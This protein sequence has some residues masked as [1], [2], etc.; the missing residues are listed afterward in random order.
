M[1]EF[2]RVFIDMR[3]KLQ[4]EIDRI[5]QIT[6]YIIPKTIKRDDDDI[7]NK[8]ASEKMY[9][10]YV[11]KKDWMGSFSTE[12]GGDHYMSNNESNVMEFINQKL[13]EKPEL[14]IE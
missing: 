8:P 13:T 5:N 7:R 1:I 2:K 4:E 12:V 10:G 9:R 6:K 14:E 3:K 11:I